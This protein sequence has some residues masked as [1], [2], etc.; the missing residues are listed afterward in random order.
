MVRNIPD[1]TMQELKI[2]CVKK[3]VSV[4]SLLLQLIEDMINGEKTKEQSIR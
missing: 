2:I 3:N 4:N 1:E